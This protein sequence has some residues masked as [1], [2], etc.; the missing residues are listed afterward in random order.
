MA[1]A[2]LWIVLFRLVRMPT[3]ALPDVSSYPRLTVALVIMMGSLVAPFMEEAVFR[4]YFQVVLEKEFRGVVAVAISSL[5]FSLAHF[6]HGMYWPKLLVY[7]LVGVAFG[8]TAYITKSTLPAIPPHIVGDLTF[9][10]I[11]WPRDAARQLVS[12]SGTDSWFWIHAAQTVVFAILAIW[13][14][15]RLA[16][17]S[18]VTQVVGEPANQ[19]A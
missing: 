1:L 2:G 16:K 14:F 6:V 3:N 10:T 9:F 18:G 13:A 7:F 4:G 8:V 15:A 19:H 17:K 12:E 11:V 5:V